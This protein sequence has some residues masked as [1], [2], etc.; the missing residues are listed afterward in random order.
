MKEY[1][2]RNALIAELKRDLHNDINMY[3]SHTEKEIR[4][5]KIYFAIDA[6]ESATVADVKE[7]VH[8]KWVEKVKY[9]YMNYPVYYEECSNCGYESIFL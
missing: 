2:E 7:I 3:N 9:G 1:I 4:D 6:L 8:A 5:D